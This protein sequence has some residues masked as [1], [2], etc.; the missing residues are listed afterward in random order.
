MNE[1]IKLRIV[2]H[3]NIY[4]ETNCISLRIKSLCLDEFCTPRDRMYKL[5]KKA[6]VPLSIS[7]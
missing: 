7:E 1:S 3:R 6:E 4:D 2:M 5:D